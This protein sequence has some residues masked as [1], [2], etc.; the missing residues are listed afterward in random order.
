MI[1][2]TISL[3]IMKIL[4]LIVCLNVI[5][6]YEGGILFPRISKTREVKSLDGLWSFTLSSDGLFDINSGLTVRNILL[7]KLLIK[8]K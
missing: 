8:L 1:S 4:G 6:C 5:K 3:K 7:T 2:E